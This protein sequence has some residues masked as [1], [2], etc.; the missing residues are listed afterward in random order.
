[1]DTSFSG[2]GKVTV[3]FGQD[4]H[5]WTLGLQSDGKYLPVGYSDDGVLR[6]WIVARVLP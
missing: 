6:K 1:M 5:C 4:D 3:D 2:D